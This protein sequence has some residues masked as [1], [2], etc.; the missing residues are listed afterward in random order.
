MIETVMD[1]VE[2]KTQN[3]KY[4]EDFK[5]TMRNNKNF[6]DAYNKLHEYIKNKALFVPAKLP[7]G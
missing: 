5:L 4:P 3:G 2:S 7:S 1:L 6:Y